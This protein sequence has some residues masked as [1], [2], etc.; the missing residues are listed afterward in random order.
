M[1][2]GLGNVAVLIVIQQIGRHLRIKGAK[3]S[4]FS[5][6][7]RTTGCVYKYQAFLYWNVREKSIETKNRFLAK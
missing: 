2:F 4:N 1:T 6:L 3:S 5:T 7:F